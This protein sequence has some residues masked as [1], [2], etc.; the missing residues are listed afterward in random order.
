MLLLLWIVG[1]AST[2]LLAF[3]A[4]QMQA[5]P[6]QSRETQQPTTTRPL[7]RTGSSLGRHLDSGAAVEWGYRLYEA[8]VIAVT[9]WSCYITTRDRL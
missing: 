3:P 7:L 4:S 5:D 2:T 8:R 1:D 9:P 6:V